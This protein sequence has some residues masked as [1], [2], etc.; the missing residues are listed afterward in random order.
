V[1]QAP[2]TRER[3]HA[4][5]F[6]IERAVFER[7]IPKVIRDLAPAL[8]R[9]EEEGGTDA[10]MRESFASVYPKEKIEADI[11]EVHRLERVFDVENDLE[12]KIGRLYA[13]VLELIVQ[14]VANIWFPD[15]VIWRASTFD[16][17]K[18]QTDLL[19]DIPDAAGDLL[20]LA[21]DVTCSRKSAA[22]KTAAAQEEFRRGKFH[23]IEYFESDTDPDRQR[24][25]RFLPR[26]VAGASR[27][28]I[29]RLAY[30]YGQY[31]RHQEI[32]S[33]Y[34][35]EQAL[36]RLQRHELGGQL[37]Q[38]LLEQLESASAALRKILKQTD[39]FK[40]S[41]REAIKERAR[42]VKDAFTALS[43][44]YKTWQQERKSYL[45][46]NQD[47]EREL[48]SP[49]NSVLTAIQQAA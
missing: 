10:E 35:K 40:E 25:R 14:D 1:E 2:K 11:A 29:A 47:A 32:G 37:Y 3:L 5:T 39:T 8:H 17:Y 44:R 21:V 38:Q 42:Y 28:S 46:G 27:D 15:C 33:R 16:D 13:M 31:L 49:A 48:S 20:T 18:R 6:G 36:E 30:L 41:Q 26:V 4:D 43:E 19:M 23:D 12:T 24:G 22:E 34:T 7:D 45:E 9:F